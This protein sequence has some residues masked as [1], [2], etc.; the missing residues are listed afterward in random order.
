MGSYCVS[1]VLTVD[2][3]DL[4]MSYWYSLGMRGAS[5]DTEDNGI[6]V[7][8]YF[9]DMHAADLAKTD[10]EQRSAL[11]PV[12]LTEVVEQDWNARWRESMKPAKLAP[13]FWVSPT[14]LPPPGLENDKWIKIEPKMAFGTG[15]HETTRLAAKAIISRKKWLK[16]KNV[17]D[18]GTGSG[19]LCFVADICGSRSC[20]G[21]EIDSDCL[22]NLEENRQQNTHSGVIEFTI[23]TL[24]CL[25]DD[26]VFDMVVMN[27][28]LTES[29]PLLPRVASILR[30]G[31]YLIWSGILDE[32]KQI[33]I[34][35]ATIIASCKIVKEAIEHEWWSGVFIK[36]NI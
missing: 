10:L 32:E 1:C 36:E 29:T 20:L 4:A 25:K 35:N 23:G 16:H 13:H 3:R 26:T 15:H 2:D 33:A 28:L 7:K 27:M 6:R 14:W 30:P 19:V 18:I 31:G 17:L 24:D 21:I 12:T 5:E 22:E 34:E 8:V 11:S 9:E